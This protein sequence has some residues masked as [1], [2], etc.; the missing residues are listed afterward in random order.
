MT[1]AEG[2]RTSRENGERSERRLGGAIRLCRRASP[3]ALVGLLLGCPTAGVVGCGD[4]TKPSPSATAPRPV[5][6]S[7]APATPPTVVEP[8]APRVA[9]TLRAATGTFTVQWS[10]EPDPI[11][12]SEP[13]AID[14]ALFADEACT[15]PLTDGTLAVDAGMPHHGHGMNVKAKVEPLGAGRFHVTGMLFHMPGRWELMFDRSRN[16]L[17]ERAQTTVLIQPSSSAPAPNA[18]GAPNATGAPSTPDAPR[19]GSPS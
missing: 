4:D 3:L 2:R 12:L 9:H 15:T 6:G 10:T 11:P 13:F 18:A 17:L 16:G 7:P 8:K 14:V 5:Q 1:R 19:G